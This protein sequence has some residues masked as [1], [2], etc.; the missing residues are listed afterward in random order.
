MSAIQVISQKPDQL[1]GVK[2]SRVYSQIARV[3]RD[4]RMQ[5]EKV[6]LVDA[7]EQSRI[8]VIVNGKTVK[9]DPPFIKMTAQNVKKCFGKQVEKLP[10]ESFVKLTVN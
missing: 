3:S 7:L 5:L 9:K 10:K 6:I 8:Q 4:S 1:I 2:T